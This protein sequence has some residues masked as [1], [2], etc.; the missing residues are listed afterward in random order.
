MK[1]GAIW[2]ITMTALQGDEEA[3]RNGFVFVVY[4]S[5]DSRSPVIL[6]EHVARVKMC[7]KVWTGAPFRTVGV[8][9]WYND[10]KVRPLMS[11]IPALLD[12][13]ARIRFR[14]HSGKQ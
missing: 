13:V 4:Y 6:Q 5:A 9:A 14:S 2:Y 10:F 11:V 3:Q 8:H 7:L 1:I 12:K